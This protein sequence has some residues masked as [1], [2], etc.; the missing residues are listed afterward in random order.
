MARS[1]AHLTA[2]DSGWPVAAPVEPGHH[3]D[4]TGSDPHPDVTGFADDVF[5]VGG[6]NEVQ[7]VTVTGEPGGGTFTLTFAGQTTSAIAYN[8]TAA[9]VEDALEAL[10]N[11]DEGDVSVSGSAG[12]PYTLTFAEQ[13]QY[14]GQNVAQLTASGASLTGGTSPDVAVATT[15]GGASS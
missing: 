7:T 12:G 3:K 5:V 6:T 11:V 1:G 9:A 15:T 2:A 4:G 8:A 10:S 13:G 14:G